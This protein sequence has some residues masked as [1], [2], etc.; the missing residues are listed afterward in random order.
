M[1]HVKANPLL[2]LEQDRA[3]KRLSVKPEPNFILLLIKKKGGGVGWG[4]APKTFIKTQT[5]VSLSLSLDTT[6]GAHL[7]SSSVSS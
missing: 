6:L 4:G 7:S 2:L 5:Q 1:R 3:A